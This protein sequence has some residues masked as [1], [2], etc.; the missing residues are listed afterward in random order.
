[1]LRTQIAEFLRTEIKL[2]LSLSKTKI[3][4][5]RDEMAHFLGCDIRI[6]PP[7]LRRLHPV[8]RGEETYLQKSAGR[9]Q[10]LAPI[11]KLVERLEKKGIGRQGG[12]PTR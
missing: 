4:H 9:P 8:T 7:A 12:K 1:M 3:T 5:A 2:T 6:T 10:I 11:S